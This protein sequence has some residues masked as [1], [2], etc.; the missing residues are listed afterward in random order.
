MANIIDALIV[1]LGLDA[2]DYQKEQKEVDVGLKKL[3]ENAEKTAKEMEARGKQAAAFVG[4]IKRELIGLFAVVTAGRG[5]SG[6]FTDSVNDTAAL[7]RLAVN[8]NMSAKELDGWGTAAEAFGGTA[9]GVR[10]SLQHIA[11]GIQEFAAT[12]QSALI[13]YFRSMG[14]E[15]SDSSGKVRDYRAIMMDLA[16][17]FKGMKPQEALFFGHNLG[18]DD[19]T[20]NMLRQGRGELSQLVAKMTQSSGVTQ[21]SVD[22]AQRAQKNWAIFNQQLRGIGQTIFAE[23]APALEVAITWL[24]KF[25][26][27]VSEHHEVIVGFFAGAAGAAAALALATI[28]IWG[29]IVLIAGAIAGLSAGVTYLWGEWQ[30][31]TSGSKTQLGELFQVA[32]NVFNGIKQIFAGTLE[33][34]KA[35]LAG[36]IQIVIDYFKLLKAVFTGNTDDIRKA[37]RNLT[38]DLGKYFQDWVKLIETLAPRI[39]AALVKAFTGAWDYLKKRYSKIAALFTGESD[40][41]T[42]DEPE[43]P[44]QGQAPTVESSD[45]QQ[46]AAPSGARLP[47]GVRN[48]NPGNLNFV[49]QDGATLESGSNARFAKFTS[50]EAGIAALAKQL[51]LYASRGVNSI[52]TIVN[53]YAPAGDGNNTA[54]YMQALAKSVGVG[55]DAQ[56]NLGDTSQLTALVKGITNHENGAGYVSDDQIRAGVRLGAGARSFSGVASNTTD[57]TIQR[58]EINTRATDAAGIARDMGSEIQRRGLTSPAATGDS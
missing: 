34:M 18:L 45:P 52:R 58:M 11:G 46:P 23:M 4:A 12:G 24:T 49:G 31:W 21:D 57:V 40:G 32:T 19:G 9:E 53:K 43:A 37:W 14:I 44:P 20:I 39:A 56:L 41:E 3:R 6:F 35:L 29:P 22:A 15:L 55:V 50:M 10:G 5:L 2:S 51:Q 26:D 28:E 7:G 47:R 1:T 16:D 48:N 54:A 38:G 33:P 8:L 17:K 30:K 42:P 25:S 27:W 36:F 13:P